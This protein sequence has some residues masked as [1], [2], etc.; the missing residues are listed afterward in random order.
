MQGLPAGFKKGISTPPR[1]GE[2]G[3]Y[4]GPFQN[5][6]K[7]PTISRAARPAPRN[8]ATPNLSILPYL[9][10]LSLIDAI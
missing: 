6:L 8:W 7:Y 9:Y 10:G 4:A 2:N 1:T 5:P 3:Y